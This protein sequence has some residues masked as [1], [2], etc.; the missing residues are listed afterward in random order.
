[1]GLGRGE[2]SFKK[3]HIFMTVPISHEVLASA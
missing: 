1:M 2:K 3:M